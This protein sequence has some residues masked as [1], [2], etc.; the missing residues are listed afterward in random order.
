MKLLTYTKCLVGGLLVLL[1]GV[2]HAEFISESEGLLEASGI[3]ETEF[4]QNLRLTAGGWINAGVTYNAND[5]GDKFNGSSGYYEMTAGLKSD[6]IGP[7][8]LGPLMPAIKETS[9]PSQ[10]T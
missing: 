4:M 8:K 6:T 10:R 7:I 5:P 2:S 1:A 9:S 3:N